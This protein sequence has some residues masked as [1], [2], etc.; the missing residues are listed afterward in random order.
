MNLTDLA[1]KEQ[2]ELEI[3]REQKRIKFKKNIQGPV[4]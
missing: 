3:G 4:Q 1:K 2:L